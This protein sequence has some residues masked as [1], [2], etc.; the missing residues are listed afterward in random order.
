[1]QE[2]LKNLPTQAGIYQYFDAKGRLLYV[3]KAKSLKQR[4]KSYWRF[5]PS[6]HP[7]PSLSPRILKMLHEAKT[8]EYMIVE[9][10][11][12]ALILENSLIKSSNP[13]YNI[14]LR[15]DKTYPYIYIDLSEDFPRFEI[16]RKLL[17]EP[18]ITYYGPFPMGG[19][20]LYESLYELYPLVQKK[21]CL[22]EKKAC[23]FYEIEK[24][25]APCERKVTKEVYHQMI[26]EVQYAIENRE[27]LTTKLEKKMLQ[28]AQQ[29][30]FEEAGKIR[31]MQK[32]IATLPLHSNLSLTT[33]LNADVIAIVNGINQGVMVKLFIRQG[34]LL[35]IDTHTFHQTHLF[36]STQAYTQVLLNSYNAPQ[37]S[38]PQS[39]LLYDAIEESQTLA[40]TLSKRLQK[41]V[42]I[43][44]PKKGAK[45]ALTQ[46]A[47]NNAL[48]KLSQEQHNTHTQ[49]AIA[50]L[51]DLQ[52][53]PYRV[54]SFDN[55]HL[56]GVATVGAMVVQENNQWVKK[57]YR[58]YTLHSHDEYGQM[59]ELLQRRIQDF[60]TIPPPDLWIIDGGDTLLKLASSLLQEAHI[61]LDVIAIAKEKEGK[62]A[63]R[64]KGGAKDTL[65]TLQGSHHLLASDTRLQWIQRQRDEAHRF[66]ITYHQ[67]KKRQEDTQIALLQTKGIGM[68]TL[69]RLLNYFG[70]F[71]AI[72]SASFDA[73]CEV[74]T[75]EIA[76]RI[77]SQAKQ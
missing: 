42:T 11:E 4:L 30:R 43:H 23:L 6:L 5:T 58:H 45:K 32:S 36:E 1:M 47:Y 40:K 69:K 38:P 15:D 19:K 70:T 62:R 33:P 53:I 13:K 48:E 16:T 59:R 29:E 20:A 41:R 24:C 71:Q 34:R 18:N 50:H 7:N 22:K 63:K 55:S 12:D 51:C 75:P 68:A 73:L 72:E 35:S 61:A 9:S 74:T 52:A 25:L 77:K 67:K 37:P 31:D 28:L 46:L 66:A 3:G 8:L 27:I 2:Q 56:M 76:L 21:R 39:I 26:Q 49:E 44:Q 14:L 17:K 10:E 54:E 57:D 60:S 64:A 65:Y